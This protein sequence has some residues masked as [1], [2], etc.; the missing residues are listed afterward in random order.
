MEEVSVE[1]VSME[2]VAGE[3]LVGVAD[4]EVSLAEK[5]VKAQVDS[6]NK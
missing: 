1:D 2:G 5:Q 3:A 6:I 4:G